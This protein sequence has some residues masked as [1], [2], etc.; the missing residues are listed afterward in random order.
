MGWPSVG[1]AE[2][3]SGQATVVP[4][5]NVYGLGVI[6]MAVFEPFASVTTRIAAT[7][8]VAGIAAEAGPLLAILTEGGKAPG[9]VAPGVIAL[10]TV[11]AVIGAARVWVAHRLGFP[12]R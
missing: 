7:L 8:L 1:D 3:S 2:F 5:L 11:G 4:A 6:L 10:A 12:N 9:L